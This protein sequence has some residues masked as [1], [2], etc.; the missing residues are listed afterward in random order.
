MKLVWFLPHPF[1]GIWFPG[2]WI[3]E[4]KRYCSSSCLIAPQIVIQIEK[5]VS[6]IEISIVSIS[7]LSWWFAAILQVQ[8]IRKK[9]KF[10]NLRDTYSSYGLL[11]GYQFTGQLEIAFGT[12]AHFLK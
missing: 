8:D 9:D 4:K 5:H 10:Q 3:F 6:V 1:S 2:K 12:V 11:H 7:H